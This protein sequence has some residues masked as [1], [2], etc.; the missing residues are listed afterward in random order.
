MKRRWLPVLA[1][2]AL[3]PLL[4]LSGCGSPPEGLVQA[5]P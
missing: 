1:V 4:S 2:A 3:A 5:P